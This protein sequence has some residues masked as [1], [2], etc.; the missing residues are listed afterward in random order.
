MSIEQDTKEAPRHAAAPAA[1][2]AAREQ[3]R[4]Q[5]ALYLAIAAGSIVGS[6]L[7]WIVGL[8]GQ[9]WIG[10]DFPWGTLV[11]NVTG[12]FVIGFYAELAGPDGRLFVGPRTRQFMM[13]GVCGGYTTFS[14]FSLETLRL[15]QADRL[16]LAA[17]YVGLSIFTWIGAVWAG[18]VLAARINRMRRG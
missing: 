7:R 2:E 12:S 13:T 16:G 6:L 11:A 18:D 17:L 4:A 1:G 3:A 9:A 14:M 5:R 15:L 8:A 10:G